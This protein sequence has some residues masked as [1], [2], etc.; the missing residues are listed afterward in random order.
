MFV[1]SQGR[2]C[3]LNGSPQ[4][5]KRQ[6]VF[7]FSRAAERAESFDQEFRYLVQGQRLRRVS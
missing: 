7:K 3:S 2:R 1:R 4:G 6:V 5:E